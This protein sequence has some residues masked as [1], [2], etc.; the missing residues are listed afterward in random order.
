MCTCVLCI[1]HWWTYSQPPA[2]PSTQEAIQGML[3][4][5]NLQ[6]SDSCLQTSWSNSQAKNNSHSSTASKK[7]SGVAGA[8]GNSKRPA[9][10]L[11]KKTQKSC[12]VDSLDMFDDDQDHLVA[13]FKDSDYGKFFKQILLLSSE[14]PKRHF[15]VFLLSI[16]LSCVMLLWSQHSGD[17][18]VWNYMSKW[19]HFRFLAELSL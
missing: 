7:Q 16:Q 3:S 4:M 2:S 12:S 17:I 9:K 13:C 19:W 18:K 15:S 6:S 1:S 11:P 8:G 10:R 14:E 5:A